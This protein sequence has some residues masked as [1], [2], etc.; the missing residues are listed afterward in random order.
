MGRKMKL[1]GIEEGNDSYR[2]RSLPTTPKRVT[3]SS[4]KR[5]SQM[6]KLSDRAPNSHKKQKKDVKPASVQ[7]GKDETEDDGDTSGEYTNGTDDDDDESQNGGSDDDDEQLV[8]NQLASAQKEQQLKN[9]A[10][11]R[12]QRL[13]VIKEQSRLA[14]EKLGRLDKERQ[15]KKRLEE[16]RLETEQKK[17]H[18]EEERLE[19]E[20]K[21]KLFRQQ[22]RLDMYNMVKKRYDQ[23]RLEKETKERY[24]KER[25]EKE[26]KEARGQ[27][28]RQLAREQRTQKTVSSDILREGDEND[29]DSDGDEEDVS[30]SESDAGGDENDDTDEEDGDEDESDGEYA[31]TNMKIKNEQSSEDDEDKDEEIPATALVN[32][33]NDIQNEDLLVCIRCIKTLA[34]SPIHS[35][36]FTENPSKCTRCT[37]RGRNCI[38]VSL[39]PLLIS[40]SN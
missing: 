11:K 35:C 24:E 28:D 33:A 31:K 22:E 3:R 29:D 16:E 4:A 32:P 17:K 2:G 30:E 34:V 27:P 20:Q 9:D 15:D 37:K 18:L 13:N 38:P 26:R 12:E 7:N 5:P 8:Q 39:S 36:D 25:L 19:Q 14:K 1:E 23:E 6:A 10:K 21:K 40:E